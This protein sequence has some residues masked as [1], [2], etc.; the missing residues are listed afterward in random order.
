M[1]ENVR[2]AERLSLSEA[3]PLESER[4]ARSAGTQEHKAAVKRWMEEAAA[5]R[6]KR[7]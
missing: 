6:A 4:M 3:L 5:K 7:N 2:Q 1:K